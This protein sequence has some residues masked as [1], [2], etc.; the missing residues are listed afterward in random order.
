MEAFTEHF[1]DIL[2]LVSEA[3]PDMTV[4]DVFERL[5]IAENAQTSLYGIGKS[6]ASTSQ[7]LVHQLFDACAH[8][9]PS[10]IALDF[11]GSVS[12][13]YAEL[14][15]LSTALANELHWVKSDTMV[16]LMFDVSFEMI[17]AILAVLKSGGAYV[18]L[19]VNHPPARLERILDITKAKV[20]LYGKGKEISEKVAGIKETYPAMSLLE[21]HCPTVTS[22]TPHIARIVDAQSLAYVFFTSGSTGVPKGVAIEHG[23]LAA[24]LHSNQGNAARY[25]NM[26]KLLVSP[27]TFDI[28]VGDIFSTL[29][30]GGTLGLV[31]RTK[32]LSNLPYW[33]EKMRT[34]H[35]ALTPS[36][37]RQ[38]PIDGLPDLQ[39]LIFV[40]ETLPV[41]L[42]F[43]M[44]RNRTV[45]NTMGPT[46]CVID[47]TEYI[48]PKGSP[49]LEG[50]QRVSIG[51]PIGQ[52]TIYILRPSTTERVAVDE[53]GEICIGGPQ[54]TRG[55]LA[56]TDLT[57]AKFVPDPFSTIP[58]ARMFRTADLGRWN[59]YGQLDH[60]GRLD[61]QVK[62]RGLRIE[63]GE[64]E[65][66]LMRSS[67]DILG[68]YVDV[69]DVRGEMALVAVLAQGM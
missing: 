38:L 9:N 47:A 18:P 1:V 42:A 39:H 41:D 8:A 55:Y 33:V 48:I 34:T 60:L 37:G 5:Q 63:T 13:N 43:N 46:E 68:I 26:R 25:P 4:H 7:S 67:T 22:T 62:L 58:G 64:I 54:V 10:R 35:L 28:S 29:T 66:V 45:S 21:Y 36:V 53:V 52:T 65:A 3:G 6:S 31:S 12:M 40:G 49:L 27:Y 61:G 15:S 19:D 24:F 20:I 2:K 51:Y 56:S 30:S 14:D 69:L 59:R 50:A 16:P 44:S 11:E 32:L 23:N 17:I 57:N